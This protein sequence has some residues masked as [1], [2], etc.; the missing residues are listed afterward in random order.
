MLRSKKQNIRPGLKQRRFRQR[1]I[2]YRGNKGRKGPRKIPRSAVPSFFTLMNLFCGFLSL[3]QVLEGRLEYAGWL[4]FLASFFDMLDGTLARLTNGTSNF[5]MELDSLADIVSFGIAPSFMIYG[6]GLSEYGTPGV[7]I[8]ALPAMAGAVRLARFN[9]GYEGEKKDTFTGIPIPVAAVS[10]VAIILNAD[11]VAMVSQ[12]GSDMTVMLVTVILVSGLMVSNIPFDSVPRASI[13]YIRNHRI[14]TLIYFT[15]FLITVFFRARG[16]L[17][18]MV[19]YLLGG[20]VLAFA[21]FVKAVRETEP[22]EIS[23]ENPS[24]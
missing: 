11:I 12:N 14:K 16:L 4:I 19:V 10:I 7:I 15:G 24:E 17:F 20:L 21:G 1:L 23:T 13:E 8:S 22:D 9:A 2:S 6:F 3:V 18:V 5:G